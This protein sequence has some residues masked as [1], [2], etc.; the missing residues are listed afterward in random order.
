MTIRCYSVIRNKSLKLRA[1]LF[2]FLQNW[3][4]HVL[5]RIPITP[6]VH[7]TAGLCIQPFSLFDSH[8][9]PCFLPNKIM[10]VINLSLCTYIHTYIHRAYTYKIRNITH[11]LN[12]Y[13]MKI[14]VVTRIM[15][16]LATNSLCMYNFC[17]SMLTKLCAT[18][19]HAHTH[20]GAPIWKFTIILLDHTIIFASQSSC[21]THSATRSTMNN[22]GQL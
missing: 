4:H 8:S 13:F 19:T 3:Y 15:A 22:F 18:H 2:N 6:E 16:E 10:F 12:Q 14:F 7:I 1:S 9:L 20:T 11:H 17:I 5:N 21:F